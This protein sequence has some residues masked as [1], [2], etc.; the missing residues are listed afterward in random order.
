MAGM[1]TFQKRALLAVA[2]SATLML[3]ALAFQYIGGY[4]PC[5][6]CYWQRWP[7][8]LAM[9]LGVLVVLLPKH[10]FALLGAALM[11]V[12]AGLGLYHAGVEQKWWEG[13]TSCTGSG[14]SVS[15]NLLDFSEPVKLVLCD[16]IVWDLFGITMAGYNA[17]IS[18]LLVVLWLRAYASSSA[19]Q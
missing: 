2:G 10:V 3:G 18:V 6:M 1:T 5:K 14:L 11:V 9:A 13:P 17:I 8:G 15:D 7:H 19:S 16:E 12:S 4:A